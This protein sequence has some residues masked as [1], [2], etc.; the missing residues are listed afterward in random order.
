[1]EIPNKVR[2][3]SIDYEVTVEDKTIVLDAVQCKG[4][5]DYEYHKINIDSS[6]QDKQGQEQTFLH[7][8]IHGIVRERKL[9]LENADDE[10]IVD[11]IA[12][13]LHQVI[14]D[15]PNIFI[16]NCVVSYDPYVVK[17][18]NDINASEIAEEVARKISDSLKLAKR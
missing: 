1:V 3:G 10:T 12:V 4:Q 5:I 6:I 7:E 16:Q 17:S 2:I 8:L 15:N 11:G 9:N 13:G 14:R 18:K